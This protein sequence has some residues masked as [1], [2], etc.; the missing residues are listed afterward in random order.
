[1]QARF[2][3]PQVGRFLSTDP[4]HFSGQDPFTFNRYAY[5][6]NNPYRYVDPDGNSAWSMLGRF[7]L[8]G[9]DIAATTAGVVEDVSTLTS[10][11]SSTLDR[12]A[13]GASLLS[14]LAPVSARDIKAAASV[15]GD[16]NKASTLKPGP[17]A[18]ESIPSHPGRP[19][20]AEQR[21]VNAHMEKNG[22]HTCG[23]KEPGTKSGNA[24]ADHQSAQAL[25]EPKEFL[26]HCNNCKARQG[27]EVLQELRRREKQ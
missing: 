17:F 21:Q 12:V 22:C 19:T 15:I 11:E 20:A 7:I 25:G 24:I 13:A 5:A 16:A 1:M 4:V 26:P 14:E 10:S 6:N 2:Y 23:T 18:K 9:G 27:G 8:K 3:D